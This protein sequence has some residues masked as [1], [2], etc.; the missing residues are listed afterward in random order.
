MS[1]LKVDGIS[2][3]YELT[4]EGQPVLFIHGLGS[5]VRDW[6]PQVD[7][8]SR[9]YQV[10]AYDVRGHGRSDKPPGPYSV[11]LFAADTAELIQAL[12]IEPCHVVGMSMGGWIAYQLAVD[13]PELLKSLVIVNATPDLVP[14]SWRDRLQAW[15]RLAIVRLLGMRRMGEVLSKRLFPKPEQE[16][17]R[18][19]FVERWAENDP[20]AYRDALKGAVGWSVVDRL[21]DINIPTLVITADQDYTSV[22][23]KRAYLAKMP[24]AE[25]VVIEDSRHGT[26]AE[27]P[28]AFN[29]ALL[30]FLSNRD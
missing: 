5:S 28:D 16:A 21:G 14:H 23:L 20:R 18:Q 13:K 4:G 15:Q 29:E 8:F 22:S 9:Q 24:Q 27:R 25:L 26:P 12:E 11:P 19:T 10:L 7:F 30:A 1:K 17:L 6:Q 2:L 3:Y